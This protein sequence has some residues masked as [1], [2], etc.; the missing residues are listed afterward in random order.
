[1]KISNETKVGALTAIAI[2]VLILGFNFLKGKSTGGNDVYAVFPNVEKLT[3]SNPVF[4]NGLQVG[5]VTGLKEKDKNMSGIV[6]TI[7]LTKDLN[8]PRNSVATLN[9]ELLGTTAVNIYLGNGNDFLKE[10]DTIHTERALGL[11]DKLQKS[12]DP[13][14]NNINKTLVSLDDVLQKLNTILDPNT[15]NNLQGI[16]ANLATS[17]ASLQKLLN[18]E[19]GMLAKTIGNLNTIT[20]DFA[21]N[22]PKIDSTF[23][24]L[25]TTTDK[26]AKANINGAIES[27][28]RT[29]SKLEGAIG[30]LD[31]K[32]GTAGALLNDRQ[33]YDEI[34]RTN[35]S[36]TILLDDLRVNPKRY[37]NISLFGGKDKKGP[38]KAPLDSLK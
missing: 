28:T 25:Q 7:T 24:N 4:I 17:S 30:K 11:T 10:G 20:S 38:L 8:I 36:L 5:K 15:R 23:S 12:I 19:T 2:T 6:V 3:P 27:M 18:T 14:I 13:A 37:I 31:S 9:S 16:V 34:R 33:L 26:L 29:M 22:G 1:M 35:R 32:E 21:R